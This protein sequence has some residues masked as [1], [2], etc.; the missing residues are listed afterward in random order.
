MSNA[1]HFFS[2]TETQVFSRID[3]SNLI[4]WYIYQ[5]MQVVVIK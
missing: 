3:V 2:A 5:E 4:W 1:E